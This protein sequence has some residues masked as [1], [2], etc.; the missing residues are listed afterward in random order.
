MFWNPRGTTL[1]TVLLFLIIPLSAFAESTDSRIQKGISQYYEGQY[2]EAV[3]NFSSAQNDRPE[4]SRIA[5]NHGNAQYKDGKFQEALNAFTQA[6]MDEKNLNLRQKSI[7]NTGNALV[8]LG[9]LEEAESAYK[10]ALTLDPSDMDAKFNLEYIREQLKQK[11]GQKPQEGQNQDHDK[12]NDSS[13]QN[14][15]GDPQEQSSD[16]GKQEESPPEH[17]ESNQENGQPS[18]EPAESE[19]M[20]AEMSKEEAERILNGLT[21]DLKSISRMQAGKSKSG[22]QG[23]DW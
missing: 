1:I 17:A 9:K 12:Q 23:N 2:Q 4:D 19:T 3:E 7:Y 5:Y 18:E 16:E 14:K 20:Q 21:E 15:Q 11:K 10:Q 22:Y 6:A 13:S 8:K